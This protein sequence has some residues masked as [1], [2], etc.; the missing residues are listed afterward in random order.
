MS[1]SA[2]HASLSKHHT[3]PICVIAMLL[4]TLLNACDDRFEIGAD[5]LPH[6]G[7]ARFTITTPD[8]TEIDRSWISNTQFSITETSDHT[9]TIGEMSIKGRGNTTWTLPKRPY[10]I[11]TPE[12]CCLM[13]MEKGSTWALLANYHD[14]T[15]LCNDLAL[16][17]SSEISLLDYTPDSRMVDLVIND[18]YRGIYQLCELPEACLTHYSTGD[19][20]LEFDAKAHYHDITFHTSRNTQPINIHYPEVREGDDTWH[21]ISQWIQTAEDALFADNFTDSI[22]YTA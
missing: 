10:S 4:V 17:M 14:Q 2:T 12:P 21:A 22:L 16:Y 20:L 8:N 19:V 11:L 6:T 5:E 3:F 1:H 9:D 15:L 7:M 18:A 13:G